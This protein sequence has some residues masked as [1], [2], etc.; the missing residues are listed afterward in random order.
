MTYLVHQYLV[1][2]PKYETRRIQLALDS[3]DFG[4]KLENTVIQS[5]LSDYRSAEIYMNCNQL[6][7]I[8]VATTIFRRNIKIISYHIPTVSM[9]WVDKRTRESFIHLW[10]NIF[11]TLYEVK[12]IDLIINLL[13][14]SPSF[15]PMIIL[16]QQTQIH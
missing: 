7:I 15:N 14:K 8:E 6:L 16:S 2:C 12:N 4:L 10:F 11:Y 1:P 5:M 9:N 3:P 13:V